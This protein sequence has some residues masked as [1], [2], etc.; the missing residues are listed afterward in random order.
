MC[1]LLIETHMN[2]NNINKNTL[3]SCCIDICCWPRQNIHVMCKQMRFHMY[4]V[5]GLIYSNDMNLWNRKS[6]VFKHELC[7]FYVICMLKLH[8]YCNIRV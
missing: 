1:N 2:M 5:Y 3:P 6:I 7:V 4:I 8:T